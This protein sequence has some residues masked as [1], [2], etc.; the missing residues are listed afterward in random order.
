MFL[1]LALL[2]L[3]PQVHPQFSM[4]IS[5]LDAPEAISSPVVA[6]LSAPVAGALVSAPVSTKASLGANAS[7]APAAAAPAAPSQPA[8]LTP[9]PL[10]ATESSSLSLPDAPT[11]MP[12]AAGRTNSAKAIIFSVIDPQ[13]ESRRDHRM[14][15]GLSIAQHTAAGFDAWTT[16][17]EISSG[18]AQ[19]LNPLLKPFAGNSSIYLA[20]QVTPVALD[21]LAHHM[22]YSTHSWERHTWWVPQVLGTASSFAA[23]FH[24]LT[25]RA[26][27]AQ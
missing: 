3:Q 12:V 23:G 20:T 4:D 13:F 15:L 16:R 2:L 10:A 18:Q 22:M 5:Q 17:R 7:P 8:A 24:N 21:F 14:W 1:A 25:V 6:G 9:V 27:P 19:E 26:T 11:P